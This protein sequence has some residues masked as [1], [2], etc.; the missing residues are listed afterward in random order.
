M[1]LA[2][3]YWRVAMTFVDRGGNT[4]TIHSRLVETDDAG[5]ASVPLADAA[6]IV[7]GYQ[8]ASDAVIKNYQVEKVF[9]DTS[10][11]LPTAAS[12]EVEMRALISDTIYQHP[13]KTGSILVPGPKDTIFVGATGPDANRVDVA[14]S[15]VVT[16]VNFYKFGGTNKALLSDGESWSGNVARGRKVHRHSSRG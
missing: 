2:A 16:L 8:A 15:I 4:A 7:A 5:D 14:D 11:A 9:I 6:A 1:A 13:E 12:S 3:A 10:F